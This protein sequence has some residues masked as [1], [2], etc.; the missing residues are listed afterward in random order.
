MSTDI[1]Q[2]V[3]F[4]D[5]QLGNFSSYTDCNAV[6]YMWGGDTGFTYHT[7]NQIRGK[8]QPK[9]KVKE[10]SKCMKDLERNP[11]LALTIERIDY[12]IKNHL[13]YHH[14]ILDWDMTI[15]CIGG[16]STDLKEMTEC[17]KYVNDI[18]GGQERLDKLRELFRVAQKKITILT[19]QGD[20]SAIKPF[21]KELKFPEVPVVAC[22]DRMVNDE[23]TTKMQW[24]RDQGF[25][26]N[27]WYIA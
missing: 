3:I 24:I 4:A 21:M 19:N 12:L 20:G 15:T 27:E 26:G 16:L 17:K 1:R 22:E 2:D 5:D 23:C 10:R 13:D 8:Q 11:K 14:I 25:C 6:L 9:H 7:Q 18:F